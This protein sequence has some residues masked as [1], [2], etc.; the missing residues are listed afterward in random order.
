MSSGYQLTSVILASLENT[1]NLVTF[2]EVPTSVQYKLVQYG[3]FWRMLLGSTFSF[4]GP[5]ELCRLFIKI[6]Q[7][8][9]I[10]ILLLLFQH[11]T[12]VNYREQAIADFNLHYNKIVV[13]PPKLC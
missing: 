12:P 6:G 8:N 3:G 9:L 4:D 5:V 1:F 10:N 11:T 2:L 13:N 7:C